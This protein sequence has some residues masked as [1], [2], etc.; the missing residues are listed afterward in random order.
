[1]RYTSKYEESLSPFC[2]ALQWFSLAF[3]I[4]LPVNLA[5]AQDEFERQAI[6]LPE[7]TYQAPNT[8]QTSV[9]L[10]RSE[11]KIGRN[12][13]LSHA[14]ESIGSNP[15]TVHQ[16]SQCENA[17]L[18]TQLQIGDKLVLWTDN[19]QQ[20]Q[21]IDLQKSLTLSY[22][23]ERKN[24]SFEI[25]QVEQPI[26]T[27]I[28]MASGEINGSFYLAGEQAGLSPRTIMNLADIFAWEVDFVRELRPGDQFKVIYEKQYLNDQYLGDGEILA[29]EL[30]VGGQRSLKAF[31][32]KVDGEYL[33]YYNENG[34]SLR[35]AFLRNPINYIR[36]S[37]RFQRNRYHPVH[38]ELRDHR[39]VDYAAPTGTPVFA[40]GDGV[41]TYRGWR[42]GFGNKVKIKHAGRY[43]TIYAHFSRFGKFK[44]GDHVKQGDVIGYV[45]MT[46]F[47][48]GPHLHYEFRI[49][50][51]HVD[52]LAVKFPDAEPVHAKYRG[53]FNHYSS[54]MLSQ[55]M[56][57][58]PEHTQLALNFE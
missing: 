27:K 56:R 39:G 25:R 29:A 12:Q 22:H 30:T 32:L 9:K 53:H 26:E 20:L 37:S 48:T 11:F 33:G 34:D 55:L 44:N 49:N 24:D 28:K 38:Q 52:P 43:E 13:T 41:I 3:L 19:E 23:L 18:F 47:A 50:G 51:R 10:Q 40:A 58:D 6:S 17:E 5:H 2:R 1:M 14:L 46:G 16:I 8:V 35:K 7:P 4:T 21:K 15:Q 31:Q 36:I 57:I 42:G 45:G 54:I